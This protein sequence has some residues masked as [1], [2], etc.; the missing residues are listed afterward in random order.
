MLGIFSIIFGIFLMRRKTSR[1]FEITRSS[2][3]KGNEL[4]IAMKITEITRPSSQK[5]ADRILRH[6]GYHR[7][8]YGSFGAVYQ[9]TPNQVVKLFTSDDVAYLAFIKMAKQSGNPHFPRFFGNPLRITDSYYAVKQEMLEENDFMTVG[10]ISSYI[11]ALADEYEPN[12]E[13]KQK[14]EAFDEEY[15]RFKEACE[16]I[17]R[18]VKQDQNIVI[19]I[20]NANV[21][22]RGVTLVF[23]DPVATKSALT[24]EKIKQLPDIQN[25]SQSVRDKGGERIEV[26]DKNDI[27][28]RHF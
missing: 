3:N 17:A 23:T 2:I 4:E 7:L 15:P 21:M 11:T 27:I 20:H 16:L 8:G 1:G 5:E 19:D 14:I 13:L 10:F 6:A 24:I 28:N 12:R 22:F 25:W 9:K 26:T 18:M